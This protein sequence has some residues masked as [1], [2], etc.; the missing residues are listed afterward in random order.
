MDVL[1]RFAP[2]FKILTIEELSVSRDFALLWTLFEAQVLDTHASASKIKEKSKE[3]FDCG[4]LEERFWVEHLNYFK[5]RYVTNGST[6][7]RFE[8]L[9][10]RKGDI[11]ELVKNVM[12]G[13][14][15]DTTDNLAVC[16][17]II[18]RFRNNFFHGLKW[19]YG[20]QDQRQ[21]FEMA[22]NLICI[23][24]ERFARPN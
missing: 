1:E 12:L 22:I 3:W 2:G 16:L 7:H 20:M 10:L 19:A 15:Q 13:V 18:L 5:D 4:L 8:A 21:N 6:N 17:I 24:M 23:C 11:P 14:N 9:N